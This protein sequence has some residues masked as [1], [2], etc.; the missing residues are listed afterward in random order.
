MFLKLETH[1]KIGVR[2][3][4]WSFHG[5]LKCKRK[6]R[7][8]DVTDSVLRS[9][10]RQY[11]CCAPDKFILLANRQSACNQVYLFTRHLTNSYWVHWAAMVPKL[12]LFKILPV[13]L[14]NQSVLRV[15]ISLSGQYCG[16]PLEVLEL[17]LLCLLHAWKSVSVP[18]LFEWSRIL[19]WKLSFC[20]EWLQDKWRF[21]MHDGVLFDLAWSGNAFP[22][23]WH[24]FRLTH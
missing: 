2:T 15:S 1:L 17:S 22:W 5:I 3:C 12:I 6:S 4:I 23:V 21:S 7:R 20:P 14:F 18:C 16:C 11:T 9:G 10:W 19:L 13:S 8:V 24:I